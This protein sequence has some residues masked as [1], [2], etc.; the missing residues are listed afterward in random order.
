MGV[1]ARYFEEE[2]LP[3]AGL[4]LVR[5]HTEKTRPPRALW[6]PYELGRPLGVPGDAAFQRRVLETVLAL[7][8][9]PS[10]PILNDYPEDAPHGAGEPEE[11]MACTVSFPPPD[12][13]DGG[14]AQALLQEIGQLRQWHQLAIERRGRTTVGTSGLDIEAVAGFIGAVTDGEAIE[15]PRLDL[16]QGETLKLA[17]EDLRAFYTESATI[18]P[19]QQHLTSAALSEW[20]WNETAAGKAFWALRDVCRAS[21]DKTMRAMGLYILVPRSELK[22]AGDNPE[23]WT[24]STED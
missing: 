5:L 2:G 18:Q 6:V 22:D 16:E 10:G 8:E 19:G 3:T 9:E 1:L 4:S 7:F 11:G 24:A 13:D 23:Y 15:N 21:D 12:M 17:C 20:F 14:T